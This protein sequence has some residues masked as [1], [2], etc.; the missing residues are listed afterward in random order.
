[1]GEERYIYELEQFGKR[2][3][4]LRKKRNLRQLD[5]EV[6]TGINRTDISKIENGL[7]NIEFYTMVR[8][9]E[10]LDFPLSELFTIALTEDD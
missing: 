1:M 10:S 5:L 4:K 6:A 9:A 8:L 7:K 2:L 3:R